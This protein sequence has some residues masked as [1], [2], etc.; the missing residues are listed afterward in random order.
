MPT[1]PELIKKMYDYRMSIENMRC[2]VTVTRPVDTRQPYRAKMKQH[3]YFAYDRGCI[4]C[5]KTYFGTESSDV[6]LY[7]DLSTPDFYYTRHP[8]PEVPDVNDGNTLFVDAPLAQP[9]DT[10][11]PR[12]VGF[13]RGH[14]ETIGTRHFSYDTLLDKF[15]PPKGENFVVNVDRVDNENFYKISYQI[16]GGEF[17]NS[18]WINPQKGYNLVRS[19]SDS[20]S[21]NRHS[22]YAVEIGKFTSQKGEIW[23]PKRVVYKLT[24]DNDIVEEGVVCDSV[25]FDV[26]DGT[27]FT[28]AGL[29]IPVGYRVYERGDRKYWDGKELVD[30]ITFE[31]E[32]V[33][34]RAKGKKLLIVNAVFL[35]LLTL[36]FLYKL[37][38]RRSN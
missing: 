31:I 15:Y 29:G 32:P 14:F 8:S 5:D 37:L 11:D 13:E 12:R 38:Q 33:D 26:Q 24:E 6:W 19:K 34:W 21:L 28:L 2:E 23:F 25:V 16:N 10:L 17:S 22:N 3:Y 27:P 30:K 1:V 18:Y 20:D 4:R 9:L 36:Y 35:A 7:Q